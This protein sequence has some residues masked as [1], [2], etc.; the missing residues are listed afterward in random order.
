VLTTRIL[1]WFDE[2]AKKDPAEYDKFFREFG[3]FLKEG[4]CMDVVHKAEIAKLLRFESSK[5]E[6]D[7]NAR[8]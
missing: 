7:L 1:K 3:T 6:S 5:K 8:T 4:A 2:N